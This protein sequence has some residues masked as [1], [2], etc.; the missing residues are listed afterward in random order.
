MQFKTELAGD[1]T[2]GRYY[3]GK[4]RTFVFGDSPP[5]KLVYRSVSQPISIIHPFSEEGGFSC[6][7]LLYRHPKPANEIFHRNGWSFS[8]ATLD[9]VASVQVFYYE[10]GR[11]CRGLL[12]TYENGGQ[13]A[14]GQCRLFVDQSRHFE[15][16]SQLCFRGIDSDPPSTVYYKTRVEIQFPLD[17]VH[18]LREGA[19]WEC[20][21]MTGW[22]YFWFTDKEDLVQYRKEIRGSQVHYKTSRSNL[23]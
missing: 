5:S 10:D 19:G 21:A 14:V 8:S 7:F 1:V 4:S 23:V 3:G 15:K 22:F 9:H 6:K 16:P 11:S 17:S 12:F 20:M 13:R 2:V 18:Q